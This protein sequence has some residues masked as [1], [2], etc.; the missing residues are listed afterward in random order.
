VDVRADAADALHQRDHLNVVARFGQMLDAAEV[1]ADSQL[2]VANGF[3]FADQV[4]L[5]RF[6]QS[7]VIGPMG[8]L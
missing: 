2:G 7:R 1:E 3:A 5:V 4:Q 6:F 8:I